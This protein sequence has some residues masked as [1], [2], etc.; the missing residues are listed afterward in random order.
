MAGRAEKKDLRGQNQKCIRWCNDG[1][2]VTVV[3]TRGLVQQEPAKRRYASSLKY[4]L[5]ITAA[6]TSLIARIGFHI[7]DRQSIQHTKGVQVDKDGL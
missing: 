7:R 6:A 4:G 1:K 2:S 3:S 5:A